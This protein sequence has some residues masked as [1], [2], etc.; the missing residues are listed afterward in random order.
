MRGEIVS[1]FEGQIKKRS[2]N[3]HTHADM[4]LPVQLPSYTACQSDTNRS[5][6]ILGMPF[7]VP[8]L[9]MA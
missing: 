6:G 7:T 2:K 8:T 9:L 1:M 4:T 5:S 3:Q